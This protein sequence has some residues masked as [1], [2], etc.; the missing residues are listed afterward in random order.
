MFWTQ[1]PSPFLYPM[2]KIYQIVCIFPNIPF[3]FFCYHAF[4]ND[5]ALIG[6][7]LLY[8]SSFS[9]ARPCFFTNTKHKVQ[10]PLI[11]HI[12]AFVCVYM[13]AYLLAH[14]CSHTHIFHAPNLCVS[15][16]LFMP[17]GFVHFIV[18]YII[19]GPF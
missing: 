13:C 6:M 15:G 10:P 17:C 3:F 9:W 18:V 8:S 4:A 1:L 12:S 2:L 16:S 11:I 14:I 5:F 7:F 19:K